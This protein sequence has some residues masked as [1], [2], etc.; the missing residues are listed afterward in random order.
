MFAQIEGLQSLTSL[1][2]LKNPTMLARY[3]KTA[4]D[5]T[6]MLLN[7]LSNSFISRPRAIVATK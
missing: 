5:S 4:Y 2:T 3:I 6:S 1:Q 7:D